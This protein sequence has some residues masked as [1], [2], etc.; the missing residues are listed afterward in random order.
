MDAIKKVQ[1]EF[2][3]FVSEVQGLT[4]EEIDARISGLAKSAV[5]V[6]HSRDSD[7]QLADAKA[8]SKEL[9]APYLDALKAVRLKTTY[10]VNL[11]KDRGQQ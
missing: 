4:K 8:L 5:E 2:P 6:Q 10:L 9:S 1:K 3:E 7:E 11:L